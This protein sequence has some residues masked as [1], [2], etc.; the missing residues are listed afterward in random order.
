MAGTGPY[1]VSDLANTY[2]LFE[3]IYLWTADRK[4]FWSATFIWKIF[5]TVNIFWTG[6]LLEYYLKDWQHEV[7]Y[8]YPLLFKIW[9]LS[10]FGKIAS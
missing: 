6:N 3:A 5:C 10:C 1:W 2:V 4:K 8:E 7:M 9:A